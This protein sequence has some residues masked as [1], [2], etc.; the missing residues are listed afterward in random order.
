MSVAKEKMTSK[1]FI[2][3]LSDIPEEDMYHSIDLGWDIPC[4]RRGRRFSAISLKQENSRK[5]AV[6][7]GCPGCDNK[8]RPN[9]VA[10][11]R[12]NSCKSCVSE[13]YKQ[14]I[15][16]KWLDEV[17]LVTSN[18][19]PLKSVAKVSGTPRAV[20]PKK[21]EDIRPQSAELIRNETPLKVVETKPKVIEKK[22]KVTETKPKVTETI[23][24]H[25]ETITKENIREIEPKENFT[26][27]LCLQE[28]KIISKP[29]NPKEIEIIRVT[30]VPDLNGLNN[31]VNSHEK[32]KVSTP[33]APTITQEKKSPPSHT[34]RRI[35][36][37]LPPPP[38]PPVN[39]PEPPKVDD[40]GAPIPPEVKVKMEAVIRELNTCR[41]VE[42]T[43]L[44]EMKMETIAPI[45][46]KIVIPVIAAD[47]HY[48]SDDN[49]LSNKKKKQ[50]YGSQDNFMEFDS[51]E[52][53][54][55]KRRRFSVACGPELF[56]ND[57]FDHSQNLH[58]S[59]ERLTSSW[60]DV[61]KA[62]K[63]PQIFNQSEVFVDAI[64]PMYNNLDNLSKPGPLTIQVRGSPIESRR[65]L[66]KDDFDPD[67]LDRRD[68]KKRVEK[69]LLKSAGSFK[70][71]STSSESE[72]CMKSPI[73]ISRKIGNLREIYEAKAKA[74]QEE[75]QFYSRRGS[76]TFGQD[77]HALMRSGKAPDLIRHIEGQKDPKPPIAPKQRRG[78][79]ASPKFYSST[80]ESPPG[81]RRRMM[82]DRD[83][84]SGYTRLDNLNARRSGR[85][86]ARTRSRRTD[87]R[88][89]YRTEDSG[90]MSTDS[91]ESKCRARYLMQL[92]P[93]K[94]LMPEPALL[95]PNVRSAV[96]KTA[97]LPIESDT[98]DLESL[99]DGRSESGGESVET[100]SVFFGNFDDSK[101]IF[102]E[103]GLSAFEP[104]NK[105][106]QSHEQIDSGFMGE[107]N[108]IL[109]G[110]SDSEHR[111]VIS[112]MT[113]HDGRAS[114][115]SISKL[116]DSPYLH[117]IE[118]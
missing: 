14:R 105:M 19:K 108:I 69:I 102:A 12:S 37:K 21:K 32:E 47:N 60:F 16:R 77:L 106:M 96:I 29:I 110:D 17:P 89:L 114:A 118:C 2:P 3:I 115:A 7:G 74:H 111:S 59:R 49:T 35:R 51:L 84:F 93:M 98:D 4:A 31:I 33:V 86:S 88:K 11:T 99:C 26:K 25:T 103:L 117:T 101:E 72:S 82:E 57:R 44:E 94:T 91:N 64:E 78:S 5:T 23:P 58:Q 83:K 113:G 27:E 48:Y 1:R 6:C 39:P 20:E 80:R 45:A 87:L 43:E 8:A 63:E 68:T 42:P 76:I 61:K 15:V 41:R 40:D 107:T 116:D 67:T 100:D 28:M 56:H 85:R 70:Y 50:M 109:S 13:D 81:D 73:A 62:V 34:S 24:K 95:L 36:K 9:K 79:D 46:P 10:L 90:Y 92:R 52:R 66:A 18:T 54:M 65:N 38:P 22:C 55:M 71:K 30:T 104:Q 112:I 53:S 75:I 97:A